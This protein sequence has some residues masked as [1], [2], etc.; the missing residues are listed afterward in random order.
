MFPFDRSEY[1]FIQYQILIKKKI[2]SAN[3]V[4][5]TVLFQWDWFW[6]CF[7]F[8]LSVFPSSGSL[9]ELS[10]GLVLLSAQAAPPAPVLS[11]AIRR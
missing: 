6:G 9:V 4:T 7:F 2:E 8:F 3:C 1:D 5:A 11:G 10:D